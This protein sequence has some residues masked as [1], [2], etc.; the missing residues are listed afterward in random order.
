MGK[1]VDSRLWVARSDV[2]K[3]VVRISATALDLGS[4]TSLAS[5]PPGY[6]WRE[7]CRAIYN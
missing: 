5:V 3:G 1:Q 2:R 4:A 6:V 7:A